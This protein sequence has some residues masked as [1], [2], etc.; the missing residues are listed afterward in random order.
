MMRMTTTRT[1]QSCSAGAAAGRRA[2]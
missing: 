1:T 2:F